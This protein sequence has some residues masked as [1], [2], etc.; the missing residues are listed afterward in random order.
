M[1]K[2][3]PDY[4]QFYPTM[5]CNMYCEFCFN[6]NLPKL[7]DMTCEDFSKL[8]NGIT[9]HPVRSLDIIGGEP[10][11][12]LGLVSFIRE[13]CR[14]GLEVNISSNG[15]NIDVLNEIKKMNH[16]A[17][18]GVSINDFGIFN[19]LK[20][21]ILQ[22][23]PIVKMV[24]GRTMNSALVMDILKLKPKK[25][26]LIYR[27]IVN[28]DELGTTVPFFQFLSAMKLWQA[29]ASRVGAIFCSGFL[30]E[31]AK[32][33]ELA[34]ARCAAGTVKLGV[35]PDGSV[36]P[37]N[38]FFGNRQFFLG[39]ILQDSFTSIWNHRILDFFRTFTKNKCPHNDCSLHKQ[40]HGGCPAQALLLSGNINSYD[41]RCA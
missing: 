32:Y 14:R 26:F 22:N 4:I 34:S 7:R 9:K 31:I 6:R 30:P 15:T 24:Y 11:L 10:T 3:S 19:H 38:L 35:L 23:K 17:T 5:Q 28:I 16:T 33:P 21:Y 29:K 37:C 12:H 20:E 41:P 1:Y 8:L 25:L 39:N 40:C 18:I 2:A 27:D 36:Y 13:A